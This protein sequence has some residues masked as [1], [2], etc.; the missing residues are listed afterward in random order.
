[1]LRSIPVALAAACLVASVAVAPAQ[2]AGATG[3][4]AQLPLLPASGRTVSGVVRDTHGHAVPGADVG[5]CQTKDDCFAA[6]DRADADGAFAITGVPDGS[7]LLEALAPEGANLLDAWYPG[8]AGGTTDPN[9]AVP[10][11][12]AGDIA[13]LE[14]QLPDGR[15][16]TGHVRTPSG[17][18]VEGVTIVG[19]GYGSGSAIES[20]ADGLYQVVGLA[21]GVF[22]LLVRGPESGPYHAQIPN[23]IIVDGVEEPEDGRSGSGYDVTAGDLENL[24]LTIVVGRTISGHLEGASG[25]PVAVTASDANPS[26]EGLV[27]ADGNFTVTGLFPGAYRL[28]FGFPDNAPVF[29]SQFPYGYFG[30]DGQPLTTT[31]SGAAIVD[32]TAGNVAGLE[33]VLVARPSIEGVVRDAYGVV[34]NAAVDLSD[35]D[36]GHVRVTTR[37]DGTF[38]A[39]NI[40]PGSYTIRAGALH[41][42]VVGYAGGRSNPDPFKAV[43]VV[44]GASAVKG[45]TIV[46]P[47]GSAISGKVTGPGGVPLA[48]ISV[49]ASP[50]SGGVWEFGP[51]GAVTRADGT[52]SVG[53]LAN[54]TYMLSFS[55]PEG[56]PYRSGYWSSKGFTSSWASATGIPV[57]D[58]SAP[59]VTTPV[60]GFQVGGHLGSS[61]APVRVRWT[62]VDA[63]SNVKLNRLQQQANAGAWRTVASPLVTA[64]TR[65]LTVGGTVYRFRVRATDYAGHTSADRAGPT[66]RVVRT[67]QASSSI[68][69]AGSWSTSSNPLASGGSYRRATAAGAT[70]SYTFTGRAIG[71]VAT[72]GPGYGQARVTVDGGAAVVI[73]LSSPTADWRRVVFS[74]SFSGLKSH[75]IRIRTLGTVGHP[76][77]SVDAFVVLR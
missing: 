4:N 70:A 48:G 46:L 15:R 42:V 8:V 66:F 65:S 41:H 54:G 57:S 55:P 53:G 68:H 14:A 37:P 36:N 71:W 74:A 23:G 44:V 56:S 59:I 18:P 50:S 32:A 77:V 16:I 30:G 69:Y 73:D 62:A 47:R 3:R 29:E 40:P 28:M 61:T 52:Y 63:G 34:P 1:M 24:D 60:A 21:D 67:Q 17:D 5:L 7:Y 43:P 25:K 35:P 58:G 72:T 76:T 2:A 31:W 12:V 49:Y 11:Q 26:F 6:M 22:E 75:T 38:V 9:A 10:V 51:G 64:G 13:G 45:L 39:S 27:D 33:A 20:D 19:T